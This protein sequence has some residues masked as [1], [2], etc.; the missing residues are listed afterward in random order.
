MALDDV[1]NGFTSHGLT[2]RPGEEPDFSRLDIPRAGLADRPDPLADPARTRGLSYGLV[3]VLDHN[4]QAVGPWNPEV[5]PETL[6]RGL[7]QMALTRAF[8]D[9]LFRMQ[10]Q[11]KLTFYMKSAGEEAVSVAAAMALHGDDMVF[12]SYRQQGIL[13]SRGR[14]LV[15]MICHNLANARDNL[16]GRQLPVH[17]AS[18]DH[19]FFSV[20]GNLTTQFPQAVGW[21]MAEAHRH[22]DR[23]AASWIGEGSSAE[24]DFHAACTLAQVYRA[25]VIL[26]VVNNQWAIST[27]QEVAGG[28]G[29]TFAAKAIGYGFPGLRV[30][31]NDF[32]AVYAATSWAAARARMGAGA[33]LIELFTYRAHSHSTSDDPSRYRPQDEAKAWPLGDPIARLKNHLIGLEEWTVEDHEAL[34]AECAE[35]VAAATKEAARYGSTA[36]GPHA[37]VETMF[38]DVYAAQPW[39]LRRQAAELMAQA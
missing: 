13:I 3:R 16:K 38:E 6:R 4:H 36:E 17:Y 14:S 12:P 15:D 21:A 27:P 18:R 19:A 5:S 32:L 8:D 28:E 39:H 10:R 37:P 26:N 33:T 34:E 1:D 2:A 20:S 11:G 23:I 25:P 29:T 7:R 24:G 30:D 9:R 31:G 22:S 35:T